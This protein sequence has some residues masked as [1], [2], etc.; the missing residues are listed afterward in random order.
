MTFLAKNRENPLIR[1]AESCDQRVFAHFIRK[2]EISHASHHVDRHQH[3]P[4]SLRGGAH[5]ANRNSVGGGLPMNRNTEQNLI[6][7]LLA[8]A[9]AAIASL[10]DELTKNEEEN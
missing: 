6:G 3:D 9:A 1:L 4:V 5:P 2:G 10:I 8:A 7:V